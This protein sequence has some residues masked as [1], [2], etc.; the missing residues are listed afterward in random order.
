MNKK[1]RMGGLFLK[2]VRVER[3]KMQKQKRQA[4][5]IEKSKLGDTIKKIFDG[6]LIVAIKN[7]LITLKK[8]QQ[9]VLK[10]K[11]KLLQFI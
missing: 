9:Q 8:I 1:K 3:N 11:I 4:D 10:K 2:L 7:C 5:S 6:L